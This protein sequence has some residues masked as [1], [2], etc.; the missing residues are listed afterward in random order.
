M[1]NSSTTLLD[2]EVVKGLKPG[3]FNVDCTKSPARDN[4]T[5]VLSHDRPEATLDVK[6]S[7]Y[8]FAGRVLWTHTESGMSA[9][10]YY[11]VDW[12]LTSNGGQRLGSGVYLFRA[13]ITSGGSEESTRAGKIVILA[14]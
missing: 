1:N 11:Y 9:N 6:L 14:Q 7:V 2:F 13:S 8:D 4:T 10:S 12:N 3:L 5:F